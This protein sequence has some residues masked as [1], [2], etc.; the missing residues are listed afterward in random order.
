MP[1]QMSPIGQF[2]LQRALD[3]VIRDRPPPR[4]EVLSDAYSQQMGWQAEMG[5]GMDPRWAREYAQRQAD[6][7]YSGGQPE[8]P[9]PSID[10][11]VDGLAGQM[12]GQNYTPEGQR[13]A[14][15]LSGELRAIQGENLRPDQ[16][17]EA[18]QQWMDK[19][20]RSRLQD[21]V[22]K[23][24]TPDEIAQQYAWTDPQSGRR[25]W[26]TRR[27]EGYS[28]DPLDEKIE[29]KTADQ[30]IATM[31]AVD[32]F[33]QKGVYEKEFNESKAMLEA[34]MPIPEDGGD[35]K[36]ASK[37]A[38]KKDML[39]RFK[40]KQEFLRSLAS[41]NLSLDEKE[42][43]APKKTGKSSSA[44][45][46]GGRIQ[47]AQQMLQGAQQDPAAFDSEEG[48]RVL[49][50]AESILDPSTGDPELDAQFDAISNLPQ[51]KTQAEYDALPKGTRY[52][53]PTLGPMEKQ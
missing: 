46:D 53:H 21:H 28:V 52:I 8:P 35:P 24:P 19:A 39:E 6:W 15:E 31:S 27:G 12:F 5:H 25:F 51:P 23:P 48:Q 37:E 10:E 3:A 40:A 43:P 17:T 50:E 47:W 7:L 9:P 13:L 49:A 41:D 32:Y 14:G 42:E 16:R 29:D 44:A 18:M 2:I 36:Q 33:S 4:H 11:Q 26:L 1:R 30:N 45:M 34:A 38:I 20:Q 22:V